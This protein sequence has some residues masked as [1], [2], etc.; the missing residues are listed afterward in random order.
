[1]SQDTETHT[2]VII[3]RSNFVFACHTLSA[4]NNSLLIDVNLCFFDALL[5]PPQI[6]KYKQTATFVDA[7]RPS[8]RHIKQRTRKWEGAARGESHFYG[9]W[10]LEREQQTGIAHGRFVII[11]VLLFVLGYQACSS[12][13]P[14]STLP[15]PPSIVRLLL[16]LPG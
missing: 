14:V 5:L 3:A 12:E 10:Q 13:D 16:L 9:T 7:T 11:C 4:C 2:R 8:Q 15:S 6:K 1:M